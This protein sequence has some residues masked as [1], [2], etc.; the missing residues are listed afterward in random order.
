MT[1]HTEL[2][3]FI[4]EKIGAKKYLEIGVFNP[5]HNFNQIEVPQKI[6]VDPDPSANATVKS[7]SDEFFKI[8]KLMGG[9]FDLIFIDGLHHV[10]QVAKDILN[11][12]ACLNAGGVIVLHDC[13]PHKESITHVPRDSREWCGD[14]Y[15]AV[16]LVTT[17]K[18]TI[19]MDY[20]CCVIHK[21]T[22]QA[23]EWKC[24]EIHWEQFDKERKKLLNLVSVQE[25]IDIINGWNKISAYAD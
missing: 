15:K 9:R 19:D 23:L 11:A 1:T 2:L 5:E 18:F 24:G 4:A 17:S 10:D 16:S 7:T 12:W 3:N 21:T 6:G 25:G 20:G 8:S 14:V 22:D 13:N